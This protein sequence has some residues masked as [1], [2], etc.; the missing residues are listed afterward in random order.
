MVPQLYIGIGKVLYI[1]N[2]DH[3]PVHRCV[4]PVFAAGLDRTFAV[5]VDGQEKIGRTLFVA[6]G[7]DRS[8]DAFGQRLAVLLIDPGMKFEI[9]S[10][11]SR[12]LEPL[13][14]LSHGFDASVLAVAFGGVGFILPAGRRA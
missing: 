12:L 10:N 7:V 6:A 2:V 14:R 11:E 5:Q 1:G 8:V 9:G 13:E 4:A 3:I